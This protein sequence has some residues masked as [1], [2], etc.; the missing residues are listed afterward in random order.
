[1]AGATAKPN[2]FLHA[3]AAALGMPCVY[4]YRA[5]GKH[6]W[7]YYHGS[8]TRECCDC[9]EIEKLWADFGLVKRMDR[10]E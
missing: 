9:G 6:C 2:K 8:G 7:I 5:K 10:D 1:M 4:G 3:I